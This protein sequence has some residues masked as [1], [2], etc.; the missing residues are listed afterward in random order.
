M[1]KKTIEDLQKLI[2]T[3]FSI[4]P[5]QSERIITKLN[6]I[7]TFDEWATDIIGGNHNITYGRGNDKRL[8]KTEFDTSTGLPIVHSRKISNF[9]INLRKLLTSSDLHETLFDIFESA[10]SPPKLIYR[11]IR[12]GVTEGKITLGNVESAIYFLFWT[13]KILPIETSK[14]YEKIIHTLKERFGIT[15]DEA[16][17]QA[18]LDKLVTDGLIEIGSDF[19]R[20]IETPWPWVKS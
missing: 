15:I 12:F 6:G 3:E 9:S 5:E 11:I 8:P 10:I 2:E 20:I 13:E 7:V 17:Y 16:Q 1:P 4:G 18:S 19:V 14:G